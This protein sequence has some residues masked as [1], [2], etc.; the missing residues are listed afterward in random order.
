[1]NRVT[2]EIGAMLGNKNNDV[3][4]ADDVCRN[5]EQCDNGADDA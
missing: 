3:N 2:Q 4:A 1:M 5:A